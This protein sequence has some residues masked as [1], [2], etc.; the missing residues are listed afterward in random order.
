M[1]VKDRLRVSGAETLHCIIK[2]TQHEM[3]DVLE[4]LQGNVGVCLKHAFPCLCDRDVS[5]LI[6]WPLC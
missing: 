6:G 4:E 2:D 3:Q 1:H 5:K